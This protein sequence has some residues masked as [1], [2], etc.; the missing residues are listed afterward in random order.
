MLLSIF[1]LIVLL[2]LLS[3]TCTLVIFTFKRMKNK[4]SGN[5]DSALE[6]VVCREVAEI[7]CNTV[8]C[9]NELCAVNKN[10]QNS[11]EKFISSVSVNKTMETHQLKTI[12]DEVAF[13]IKEV[14][15]IANQL[16]SLKFNASTVEKMVLKK[17]H[18]SVAEVVSAESCV[19]QS[20]KDINS[21]LVNLKEQLGLNHFGNIVGINFSL[22]R[23]KRFVLWCITR[24]ML[25]S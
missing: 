16:P 24:V 11:L 12:E 10:V 4:Q 13:R 15:N 9:L 20:I 25:I 8:S 3:V 5:A 22:T 23:L 17:H 14:N 7:Y 6:N 1:I 2:L 21:N 19:L 18:L